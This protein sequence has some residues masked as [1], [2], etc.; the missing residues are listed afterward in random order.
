MGHVS[1]HARTRRI[2]HDL[3]QGDLASRT[4]SQ[5]VSAVTGKPQELARAALNAVGGDQQEACE[6]LMSGLSVAVVDGPCEVG[7]MEEGCAAW[8]GGEGIVSSLGSFAGSCILR[9]PRCYRGQVKLLTLETIEVIVCMCDDGLQTGWTLEKQLSPPEISAET[10]KIDLCLQRKTFKP[11]VVLLTM[12]NV[13]LVLFNI[14]KGAKASGHRPPRNSHEWTESPC[15]LAHAPS[16]K[17]DMLPQTPRS[18]ALADF[19]SLGHLGAGAF[20]SVHLAHDQ[21]GLPV[22]VKCVPVRTGHEMR[23]VR[24]LQSASHPNVVKFLDWFSWRSPID[25]AGICI[26]MEY[27]P[28]TLH[29]RINGNPLPASQVRRFTIQLLTAAAHLDVLQ[30]C[31]RDL[32]PENILISQDDVLKVGDFGSAKLLG[33]APSNNYICSRWWRAPELILGSSKYTTSIDWWSCGCIVAEMMGGQPLFTGESSWGQMYAIV[34]VLG[35]PTE[36]EM[37]ELMP[38]QGEFS[39]ARLVQHFGSLVKLRRLG[40]PFGELFPAFSQIPGCLSIPRKLLSY[41]PGDR[42]HPAKLL[43][44]TFLSREYNRERGMDIRKQTSKRR[45]TETQTIPID[46][47]EPISWKRPCF[48]IPS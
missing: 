21:A 24:M 45:R 17:I 31:H 16:D 5:D 44:A 11:G 43:S 32:K 7:S 18:V 20:G 29:K 47:D 26:V 30:I 39:S 23:E 25:V 19:Q 37:K 48:V 28:E 15:S 38:K 42:C 27:L 13:E 36:R 41:S 10:W 1:R 2:A 6:L 22:A 35:T 40:R 4:V 8:I 9:F 46:V 12:E 3:S 33:D 14:V 34:R